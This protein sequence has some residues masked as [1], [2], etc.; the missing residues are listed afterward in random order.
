VQVEPAGMLVIVSLPD[1]VTDAVYGPTGDV[2]G[3]VHVT[4]KLKTVL[5]W[6]AGATFVIV[7]SPVFSVLVTVTSLVTFASVTTAALGL[8]AGVLKSAPGLVSTTVQL[9]PAGIP[10][11]V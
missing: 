6:L 4:S 10:V 2:C 3:F 5:C 8:Y 7:R 9:E 11:M 1:P